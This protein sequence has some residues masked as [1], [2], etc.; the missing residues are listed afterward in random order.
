MLHTAKLPLAIDAGTR[1]RRPTVLRVLPEL[2]FGGVEARVKLQARL[3]DRE[4]YNLRVCVF[5]K[6]GAA[7]EEV[8]ALGIP[9][10]LLD[11]S[12]EPRNPR[13]AIALAGYLRRIQPDVLHASIA[14]ANLHSLVASRLVRIP[15]VIAEE[16]GMPEHSWLAR[17]V[18]RFAYR[19][20]S[21]VVGVTKA[22]CDYVR[23]VDKAP[24]DRVRL[25]Y[26]CA[27]PRYFPEPRLAA[28][29]DRGEGLRILLAARLVPVKNHFLF[30]DALAPL[31]Q[32]HSH[33]QVLIAGEGPLKDQLAAKIDA[34]RI[35]S[36]VRLLGFRKD[37]RE[38]LET[39]H[40][41]ALPSLNEGCSISL[42]EAMASGVHAIGSAVPGI[43]EV[44][45]PELHR[46]WTASPSSVEQWTALLRRA[47]ELSEDERVTVATRAQERA[48]AEFSPYSYVKR[49]ESLYTELLESS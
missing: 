46:H 42:I 12:P 45:G 16:T 23:E 11:V 19:S 20:A 2:D 3:H 10:D 15:V 8:R 25:I 4:R 38:L 36:H 30:L 27:D 1:S 14:E 17:T 6:L 32:R 18:Y 43:R 47:I 34:L 7:G 28:K 29:R 39:A 31:L 22:V 35:G 21:A 40:V 48:Y 5:H 44:M 49:V 41:Y 9:V 13:A 33:V 24:P 37:V 26:N